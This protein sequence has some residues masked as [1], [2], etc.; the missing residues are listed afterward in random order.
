MS[1]PMSSVPPSLT[2]KVGMRVPLSNGMQALVVK[3]TD[4]EVKLD[5]NHELAGKTLTFD[6]E[7]VG[8]SEKVLS[9]PAEGLSRAVFGLGCF[10]GMF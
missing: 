8:F 2:L 3:V 1:M 7:L 10:W 5:A 4:S 6:M 9:K